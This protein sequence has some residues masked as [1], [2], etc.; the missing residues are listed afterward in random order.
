MLLYIVLLEG[1]ADDDPINFF[2][3]RR[4]KVLFGSIPATL[5]ALSLFAGHPV[6][7]GDIMPFKLFDVHPHL[8]ADDTATYPQLGPLPNGTPAG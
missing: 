3:R 8:I 4:F 5:L 2:S 1:L 6:F 7:A